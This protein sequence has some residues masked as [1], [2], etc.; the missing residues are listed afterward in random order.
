MNGE[1]HPTFAISKGFSCS[2][3][4]Q[5]QSPRSKSS[6]A[7]RHGD[8]NLSLSN[9]HRVLHPLTFPTADVPAS[10]CSSNLCWSVG[11]VGEGTHSH[12]EDTDAILQ[13]SGR[14]A[15]I[16]GK[17]PQ[18]HTCCWCS[19]LVGGQTSAPV[20]TYRKQ[21]LSCTL[22]PS[23]FFIRLM[24]YSHCFYWSKYSLK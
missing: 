2:A 9:S 21:P 6:C 19:L 16:K 24:F 17:R 4:L 3:H 23:P 15:R 22:A 13:I 8:S 1:Q 10:I 14:V 18:H 20:L 11:Q 5:A 7:L 12:T